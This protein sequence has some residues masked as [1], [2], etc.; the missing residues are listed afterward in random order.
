MEPAND[1][2]LL[3]R[4]KQSD[5]KAFNRIY[6]MYWEKLFAFCFKLTGSKDLTNEILQIIFVQ[7]WEKRDETEITNLKS[8]LFQSVKYQFFSFYKKDKIQSTTLL[9]DIEDYLIDNINEEHPEILNCLKLA[10]DQLPE[11]R[12]EILLLSKYQNRSVN[13]ISQQL[14]IAP[15]TVRNQVSK[16]LIQL[17]HIMATGTV[18][19]IYIKLTL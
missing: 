15:Q 8:Y 3:E 5:H 11:K 9:S 4:L 7:L 13:E 19:F 1:I 18:V 12:K 14:G 6:D 10:L 17:R 16:A 2:F